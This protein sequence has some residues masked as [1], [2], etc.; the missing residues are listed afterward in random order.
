MFQNGL[1]PEL[2]VSIDP[3]VHT[4]ADTSQ[5]R[6]EILVEE[7]CVHIIYKGYCS[8]TLWIYSTTSNNILTGLWFLLVIF[9][10]R[11]AWSRLRRIPC[12]NIEIEYLYLYLFWLRSLTYTLLTYNACRHCPFSMGQ[13]PARTAVHVPLKVHRA[14]RSNTTMGV[15]RGTS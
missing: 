15:G 4:Q 10:S 12:C 2:R 14:L 8:G 6:F 1:K 7:V 3:E 13:M 9:A 11:A 5:V